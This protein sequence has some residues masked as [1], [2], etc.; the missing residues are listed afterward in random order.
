MQERQVAQQATTE[1]RIEQLEVMKGKLLDHRAELQG[2][3]DRLTMRPNNDAQ[4]TQEQP[5]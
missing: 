5:D 4:V 3:I 2:K 1:E